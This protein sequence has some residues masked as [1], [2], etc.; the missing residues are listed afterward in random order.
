MAIIIFM[1]YLHI[2]SIFYMPG[3][4]LNVFKYFPFS[5][6]HK[7]TYDNTENF[8]QDQMVSKL[9]SQNSNLSLCDCNASPFN[10]GI[11]SSITKITYSLHLTNQ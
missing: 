2:V 9:Q 6:L 1:I 10:I 5:F 3:T 11:L 4:V 7:L 8:A